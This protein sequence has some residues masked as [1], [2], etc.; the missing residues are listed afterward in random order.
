[1][2]T[3]KNIVIFDGSI[4]ISNPNL[5]KYERSKAISEKVLRFLRSRDTTI[6]QEINREKAILY[7][8]RYSGEWKIKNASKKLINRIFG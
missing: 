6:I 7:I 4:E 5:H 3:I 8:N 2:E 1:M